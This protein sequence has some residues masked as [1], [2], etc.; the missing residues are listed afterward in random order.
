MKTET[1]TAKAEQPQSLKAVLDHQVAMATAEEE[2]QRLQG[3]KTSNQ[4]R[5]ARA[6]QLNT[7][8][9]Q[10]ERQMQDL[11]ADIEAGENKQAELEALRESYGKVSDALG[12][13]AFDKADDVLAG[14]DRKI[15]KAKAGLQ[16]LK[17]QRPVLVRAMLMEMAEALGA[18]YAEAALKT[19]HLYR[20]L[21]AMNHILA[22]NG[23]AA[24]LLTGA[25][26]EV[27]LFELESVRPYAEFHNRG[28]MYRG[29]HMRSESMPIE[30]AE[31]EKLAELGVDV[32]PGGGYL[33]L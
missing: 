15:D 10:M 32:K 6:D 8:L 20:R 30:R 16:K 33:G 23:R 18:E 14:L 25:Q 24:S 31:L 26:L 9:S 21:L 28:H 4:E 1:K 3:L 11:M 12:D 17:E 2:L 7:E 29:P 22:I 5:L 19:I 13:A 27:P